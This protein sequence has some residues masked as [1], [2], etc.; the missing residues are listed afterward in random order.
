MTTMSAMAWP[1]MQAAT[2]GGMANLA[3]SGISWQAAKTHPAGSRLSK[4]PAAV[5]PQESRL[6]CLAAGIRGRPPAPLP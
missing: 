5:S 2:R 4:P 3:S 1:M 6:L